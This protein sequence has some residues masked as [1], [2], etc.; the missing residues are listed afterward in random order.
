MKINWGT[1]IVL[2]FIAF[3]AFI[4][5]FVFLASSDPRADHDMVTEEYYKKELEYQK[6][7]DASAN[8]TAFEGDVTVTRLT[9]GLRIDFPK[10]MEASGIQGKV[11]LY[12]PS[13]EQLD[14][15]M[16]I[17]EFDSLLLIPSS[18]L[19]DGRWDIRMEWTY[20]GKPYLYRGRFTY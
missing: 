5:Y 13:N 20:D 3:I 17:E 8:L 10:G 19:L 14:F 6:E 18:R 15:E 12:R 11:S 16:S 7:L 4:L 1:G 2:A 9:E